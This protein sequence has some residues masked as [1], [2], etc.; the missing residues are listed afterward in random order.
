MLEKIGKLDITTIRRGDFKNWLIQKGISLDEFKKLGL[1]QRKITFLRWKHGMLN[2]DS[3]TAAEDNEWEVIHMLQGTTKDQWKTLDIGV[4]AY[5][6]RK[7]KW[8][9]YCQ[10]I[11]KAIEDE[12]FFYSDMGEVIKIK[13]MF[14][15]KEV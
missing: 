8:H 4:R 11:W 9:K 7:Y 15:G 14:G 1:D 2:D 6:Y 3:N 13:E 10:K 12:S 5:L